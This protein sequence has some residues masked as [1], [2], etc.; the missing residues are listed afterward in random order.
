[1]DPTFCCEYFYIVG[2]LVA[3]FAGAEQQITV[4]ISINQLL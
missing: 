3:K 2:P 4:T 1:M